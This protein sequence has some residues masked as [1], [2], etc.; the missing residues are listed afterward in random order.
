MSRQKTTAALAITLT[1]GLG[2][3]ALATTAVAPPEQLWSFS[4][5]FGTFDRP[6]AQRGF[7]VYEEACHSCHGLQFI[8]F[9]NLTQ[10]GFS[11]DQVTEIAAKYE[12][13]AGPNDDGEMFQTPAKPADHVPSPFPNE[14]AA[15]VANNGALPPDLSLIVDARAGGSN[16][17]YGVL[18]G[19]RDPAPEGVTVNPGM[20]YNEYF[21]G[22]QIAMPPPLTD[23]RVTY[24]DGTQATV[25]QMAHDVVTFLTWASEPNMEDRKRL[26]VTVILFLIVLTGFLYALKRQI[27]SD[28]SH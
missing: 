14:Q 3:A 12:V 22:H 20:Y 24:T 5:I 13:T 23:D 6:A 11:P 1:L 15:R 16:Y 10:L 27:W 26:G 21:A 25:S 9:R 18:T 17:V 7:Q 4:G 8:A 2:A 28:V 19:Y